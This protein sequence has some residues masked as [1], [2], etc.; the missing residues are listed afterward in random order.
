MATTVGPV[1]LLRRESVRF[2]LT[3]ALFFEEP[4]GVFPPLRCR[5]FVLL[6]VRVESLAQSVQVQS[7][8]LLVFFVVQHCVTKPI[9]LT[10][11]PSNQA[12]KNRS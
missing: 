12:F 10:V 3:N 1:R 8:K 5:G 9:G 11:C 2:A 4:L 7:P 6:N